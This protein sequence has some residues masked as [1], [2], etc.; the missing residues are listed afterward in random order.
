M[1]PA[2]TSDDYLRILL[3]RTQDILGPGGASMVAAGLA[4]Q[5]N[6]VAE[7]WLGS[8]ILFWVEGR[9]VRA[10]LAGLVGASALAGML[11][12]VRAGKPDGWIMAAYLATFL[13][14]PFYDQMGRF[15]FPALPVLVL[16]A[17]LAAGAALRALGRRAAAGYALLG[18]LMASLSG[19]ALA[20]IYQ[21]SQAPG[22]EAEIVDWYRSPDLA[23]ARVRARVHLDLFADMEAIR[24]ATPPEARIAWVAPSYLAL[25]AGRRGVP[26]PAGRDPAA[27]RDAVR[28]LRAGYVFVSAYH[29]RDTLSRGSWLAGMEA[30]NGY[31]EIVHSR[32]RGDGVVTSVLFK[33]APSERVAPQ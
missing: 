29:P 31:A 8:L 15:L 23:E 19:P 5:A 33:T 1:R 14:W 27:Y 13:A 2:S 12:R 32:V 18:F 25:L 24:L 16:Y 26:A 17:F 30:M 9:P 21:R 11:L 7:G 22:R 20:F 3:G 4:R 6:A 28:D 10:A